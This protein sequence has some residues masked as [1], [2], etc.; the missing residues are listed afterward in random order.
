MWNWPY[1]FPRCVAKGATR[2]SGEN[3]IWSMTPDGRVAPFAS[4][5]GKAY[6]Q[7]NIAVGPDGDVWA[8]LVDRIWR[9]DPLGR[10]KYE[11]AVPLCQFYA[12]AV[13]PAGQLHFSSQTSGCA[14]ITVITDQ[15]PQRV[16]RD[17][18]GELAFDRGGNLYVGA[19]DHYPSDSDFYDIGSWG[20]VYKL[21]TQ[22]RVV[23]DVAPVPPLR[24]GLIFARD[25][26]RDM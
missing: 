20:R 10:L 1:A 17:S 14:G 6:G 22:Y 12:F 26:Q 15:G 23:G 18:T 21:D 19:W 2:P 24:G 8:G 13:S 9:F 4:H 16:V 7:F 3:A 25:G 5:L 11:V